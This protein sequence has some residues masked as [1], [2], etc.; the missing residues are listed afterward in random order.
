M[1]QFW[2]N[3]LWNSLFVHYLFGVVIWI[4]IWCHFPLE[5]FNQRINIEWPPVSL[6]LFILDLICL[7]AIMKFWNSKV[8][9]DKN[10]IEISKF[11]NYHHFLNLS[12]SSLSLSLSLSASPSFTLW[13]LTS[14][15]RG[16]W[17]IHSE[18]STC[19]SLC[20]RISYTISLFYSCQV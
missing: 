13:S 20:L 16:M 17:I 12:T 3:G 8:T 15:L 18:L 19:V 9:F 2:M 5:Y 14:E 6:S 11:E 7:Y 1:R 4:S 10:S